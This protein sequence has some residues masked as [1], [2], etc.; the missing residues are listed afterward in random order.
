MTWKSGRFRCSGHR[1]STPRETEAWKMSTGLWTLAPTFKQGTF[2]AQH[3]CTMQHAAAMWLRWKPSVSSPPSIP[4]P[5]TLIVP[6]PLT[7]LALASHLGLWLTAVPA[8]LAG[9]SLDLADRYG[10]TPLH[11]AASCSQPA[12]AR[13]LVLM[14]ANI[15]AKDGPLHDGETPAMVAERFGATEVCDVLEANAR[16]RLK[17]AGGRTELVPATSIFLK[18]APP[19]FSP[20]RMRVPSMDQP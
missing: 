18:V 5:L 10:H 8:V 7:S 12:V 15:H 9:A 1:Y 2:M 13:T 6:L 17:L 16:R 20:K 4:L 3:P 11:V 14:G 19:A